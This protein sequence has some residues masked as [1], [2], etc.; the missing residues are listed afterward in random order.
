M[1]RRRTPPARCP[2]KAKST[3]EPCK[4]V[5][6]FGTDHVGFGVCRWHGGNS[7]GGRAQGARLMAQAEAARLGAEVDLDP[8][9]ALAL[10]VRLVAGEVAFLRGKLREAEDAD[11]SE[12][13]L[14]N[15][16]STFASSIERLARVGKLGV[17]A[18]V[19][20]RRLQLDALVIDRIGGAV[21]RAIDDARLD[22]D[23]RARLGV[24]LHS[25]L[26]ELHDDELRPEP[27]ALLA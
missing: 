27:K 2:A 5:A 22:E 6:G 18:D 12:A 3:G 1:S 11:D 25:R 16:A 10:A 20:E 19:D 7:P 24:A 21:Q 17:D 26:G 9:D 14:R 8:A 15:L 23:A 13:A 4:L